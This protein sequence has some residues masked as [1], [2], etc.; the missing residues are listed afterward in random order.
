MENHEKRR[1]SRIMVPVLII[2]GII[3]VIMPIYGTTLRYQV[4]ISVRLLCDYL[5]SVF[6]MIG[7]WTL[8][9]TLAKVLFYRK[10]SIGGMTLAILLLYVGAF[11]MGGT[12]TIFGLTVYEPL[13]NPGFH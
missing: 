12:V 13:A 5:G 9:I 4:S 8:F 10:V 6:Q 1:K 11:L 2:I 7:W 3:L